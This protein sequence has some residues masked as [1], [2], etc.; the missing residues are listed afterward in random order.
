MCDEVK[1]I[2]HVCVCVFFMQSGELEPLDL[3]LPISN[4]DGLRVVLDIAEHTPGKGKERT[5]NKTTEP[6]RVHA[7]PS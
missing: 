1:L 5:L 7:L 2:P 6:K 4:L 3:G